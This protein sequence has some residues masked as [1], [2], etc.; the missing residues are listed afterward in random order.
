MKT[1]E[2]IDKILEISPYSLSQEEKKQFLLPRLEELTILHYEK[3]MQYK[4]IIDRVYGGI[5]SLKFKTLED[6]PFI[7]VSLFKKYELSSVPKNEVVKV[8]TSS[9]TTGQEVSK[10]YLDK[11]TA[12]LQ[13]KIL[14]KI[15]Q[16]FVGNKRLPMI[17][18]DHKSVLSDRNSYSARGA[19]IMGLSQFGHK[20]FYA[21]N[22]DMSLDKEG[23]IAYLDEVKTHSKILLFG[24]TFM[25]WKHFILEL[26]QLNIKLDLKESI[27]IHS[28]GWK[29]LENISVSQKQFR[30]KIKSTTGI[31]RCINFYGMVEQVGSIYFENDLHYFQAPIY[32]DIIIRSP[33]TLKPLENN[34]SGLVQVLSSIPTSY[35]GHSLLTEDIGI[36]RNEDETSLNMRGKCFEIIGRVP[37]AEVRGCSDTFET[38][39]GDLNES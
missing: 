28:G 19:G 22:D 34:E 1:Q 23:F 25:I 32:S 38:K 27:L 15:V 5:K 26:E 10:I 12:Q 39:V 14:I 29:K 3:C 7:P 4:N 11:Q 16:H 9:G 24:F 30:E 18:L 6:I 8:L 13:S 2:S 33:Y 21:F 31:E 36:I 20:I 35:P 17:I 37:K